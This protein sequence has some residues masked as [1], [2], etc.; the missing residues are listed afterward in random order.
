MPFDELPPEQQMKDHLF[1]GI[2]T[3]LRPFII[4]PPD[5][6]DFVADE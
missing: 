2:M 4:V 1:R 3:A 6:C 5:A